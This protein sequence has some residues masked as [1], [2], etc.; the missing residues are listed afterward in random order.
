MTLLNKDLT[1]KI[2]KKNTSWGMKSGDLAF[3]LGQPLKFFLN[4]RFDK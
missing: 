2:Q 3:D 4:Q 1:F